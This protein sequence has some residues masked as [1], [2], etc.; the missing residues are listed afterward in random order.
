ML[1][2]ESRKYFTRA[3]VMSGSVFSYFALT[4]ENHRQKMGECAHTDK[5]HQMTEYVVKSDYRDLIQCYYQYDLGI[6]LKP[7]WVPTIEVSNAV[8]PFITLPPEEIWKSRNAPVI[9]TFFTFVTQ[10]KFL[11]FS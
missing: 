11:R 9:D 2:E 5:L 8:K 10:V 6:T 7:D 3:L 4:P 1:N